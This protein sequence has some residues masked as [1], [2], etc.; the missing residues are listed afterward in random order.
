MV[1]CS[2]VLEHISEPMKVLSRLT[3]FLN[4][5]GILIISTINRT[6]LGFLFAIVGAEY[7]LNIVPKGTH[8]FENLISSNQLIQS[9]EREGLSLKR[10]SGIGYNPITKN[11]QLVRDTSVNFILAAENSL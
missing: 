3:S 8:R 10:L 6:F 1:I 4:P 11:A 5:G 9:I 2:E 7:L